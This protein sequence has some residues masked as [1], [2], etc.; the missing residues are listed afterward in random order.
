MWLDGLF[1]AAPFMAQYGAEFNEPQWFDEAAHQITLIYRHTLCPKTGLLYHGWDESREQRWS[2]PQTGQS[3]HFWSRA[4]GWYM[5]AVVDV[6][7]FLPANH[8][9]RSSVID[10]LNNVSEA[11]LKVRDPESYL[12]YQVTDAGNREGNY[13]EA[14]GSG[15]FAYV[16]AKG[17]LKGYLPPR[18]FDEAKKTHQGMIDKLI[19]ISDRGLVNLE[20]TCGGAG[21]GG[22][23]YRDGSYNYYINE[24]TRRNDPKGVAAFIMTGIFL[25]QK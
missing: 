9:Q 7:D 21:L 19:T 6:L 12:W 23:P 22:N 18:F 8:P 2:N 1:M 25:T 3:P 4:I 13:L 15:M 16:F 20:Q 17:A 14:S 11:L 5:M 10:I 24:R